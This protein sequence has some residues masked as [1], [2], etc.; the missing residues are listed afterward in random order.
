VNSLPSADPRDLLYACIRLDATVSQAPELRRKIDAVGWELLLAE[1]ET[2][3]LTSVL[4]RAVQRLTLAPPVPAITLP[5]GRMT[6][7]KLLEAREANHM[8][9][10]DTM[11]ARLQ[12]IE[13]AFNAAGISA[14]VLKGGRSLVT[15][16][17]DWRSL[18]D[19]DLL[20]P[21]GL[22]PRAQDTLLGLGY[23]QSDNARPRQRHHHL[24]ELYRDDLPG[25]IEI[26]R[27][28]GQSRVEQFLSTGELLSAG[29][30]SGTIGVLPAHLHVLYGIMHHHIG[31]GAVKRATISSK[32][33]YEF[34]AE[35]MMLDEAE[36]V[37]LLQRASRHPRLLAILELWIAAAMDRYGLPPGVPFAA[38]ADAVAWWEAVRDGA[39]AA[40]GVGLE[41]KAATNGERM[42]R[43]I[44]GHQARKRLYWWL[45]TPLTFIK[46]PAL[47]MRVEPREPGP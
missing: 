43:A 5:N 42:R 16:S 31:H 17:P 32:G 37:A 35:L 1:A 29:R 20:V 8:A 36:R 9:R 38:G 10:R 3:R 19:L 30:S 40:G 2:L 21:P 24:H 14:V 46:H 22:A 13:A 11:R 23:R 45:T 41:L 7:P 4:V 34:A 27:R 26:H 25:W 18:R 12:E 33:L 28:A 44:G 39:P 47:L 6:I 15:G